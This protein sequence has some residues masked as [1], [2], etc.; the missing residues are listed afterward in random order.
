MTVEITLTDII[1]RY[2]AGVSVILTI[3]IIFYEQHKIKKWIKE[4]PKDKERK[5]EQ[6]R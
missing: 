3:V 6:T 4:D 5:N 1:C 2:V